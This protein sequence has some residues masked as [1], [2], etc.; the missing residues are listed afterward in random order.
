M[1]V[2]KWTS[3]KVIENRLLRDETFIGINFEAIIDYFLDFISI[4]GTPELFDD[5]ITTELDIVDYRAPLPADFVEEIFVHMDNKPAKESTDISAI[6]RKALMDIAKDEFYD[7]EQSITY[8]IGGG[9]IYTSYET[10]KLILQY[11]SIKVDEDGYPMVPD[12][13]VFMLALQSYIELQFLKILYRAGKIA[14]TIYDEAKQQYAWNVGRYETHAKRLTPAKMESISAMFK[15]IHHR[16]NE[17]G[18]RYKNL[19]SQ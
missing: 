11:K 10:G 6:H 5:K 16:R 3:L 14:G 9:Y 8:K 12:D 15:N 13:A 17:F 2:V 19:S 4:V 1:S 7:R 18:Q